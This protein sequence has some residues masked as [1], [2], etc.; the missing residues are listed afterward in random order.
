MSCA[1]WVA[2]VLLT[3]II[4]VSIFGPFFLDIQNEFRAGAGQAHGSR[5]E[6]L[7]CCALG[8]T[9]LLHPA[10]VVCMSIRY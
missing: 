2:R 9:A 8:I 6:D 5:V 1:R 7:C 3:L 10:S 4:E